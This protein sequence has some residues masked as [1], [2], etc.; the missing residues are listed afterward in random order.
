MRTT[1]A[2]LGSA[3]LPTQVEKE[4]PLWEVSLSKLRHDIEQLQHLDKKFPKRGFGTKARQLQEVSDLFSTSH[5]YSV[6]VIL[7]LVVTHAA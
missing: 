7:P 5:F 6:A 3:P 4:A 1:R 2:P